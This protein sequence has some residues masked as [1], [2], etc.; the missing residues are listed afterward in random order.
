MLTPEELERYA[1]HIVRCVRS[2]VPASRRS[3]VPACW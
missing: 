1:R 2:A 3:A